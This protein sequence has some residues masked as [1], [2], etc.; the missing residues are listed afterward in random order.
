[1][2]DWTINTIVLGYDGSGGSEKAA[3][4]AATIARQND[5]R[6]VVVTVFPEPDVRGTGEMEG[7]V[8]P[9]VPEAQATAHG[10][11]LR[12]EEAGIQAEADILEGHPGEALLRAAD[13]HNADLIV[14]G[15]RGHA[16]LA[17]L[18]LGSTSEHVVRQAKVPVLVGH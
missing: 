1:M 12:L 2:N 6:L 17:E 9:A 7:R 14:V 3:Q 16:L 13:A 15:R 4:L 11:V 5:A 10:I 8:N 18:L